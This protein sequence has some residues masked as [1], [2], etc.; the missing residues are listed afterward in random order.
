VLIVAV[1][2]HYRSVNGGPRVDAEEAL[3]L[4][5]EAHATAERAAGPD[6]PRLAEF[7]HWLAAAYLEL[8][9]VAEAGDVLER[10]VRAIERDDR[11]DAVAAKVLGSFAAVLFQLKQFARLDAVVARRIA[12]LEGLFGAATTL[13][14]AEDH[15]YNLAVT[16]SNQAYFLLDQGRSPEAEPLVERALAL[17]E[18]CHDQGMVIRRGLVDVLVGNAQPIFEA[19]GRPERCAP[20]VSIAESLLATPGPRALW[21]SLRCEMELATAS[22][23][24]DAQLAAALL[25]WL[26]GGALKDPPAIL[27]HV[28]EKL[29][30]RMDAPGGTLMAHFPMAMELVVQ[31]K[32]SMTAALEDCAEIDAH[33]AA[34]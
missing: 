33:E 10:A 3:R 6:D 28:L 19:V 13:A 31:G 16:C 32:K 20:F 1:A 25:R 8:G 21:E 15:R 23:A 27:V 14:D 17:L 12:I 24:S 34:R 30:A 29:R 9:R 26:R 18:Q 22:G 2:H 11:R 7:S 4:A 5:L